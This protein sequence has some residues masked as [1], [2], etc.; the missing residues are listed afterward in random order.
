MTCDVLQFY[1]TPKTLANKAWSLFK[2]KKIRRVLDPSAG[3]G[4]LMATASNESRHYGNH[5]DYFANYRNWDAVEINGEYHANIKAKGGRV[6]GFDFMEM[7]SAVAYSHIIMNPP[8]RHGVK[9]L[10]HAWHIAFDVEIVAILNAQGVRQPKTQDEHQLNRLIQ[11][12]GSV[13]FVQGA[14]EDPDT[15]RTTSVEVALVHITK[16]GD[17]VEGLLDHLKQLTKHT[18]EEQFF[19]PSEGGN[20]VLP[21][22]YIKTQVY[23]YKLALVK[24]VELTQA[25]FNYSGVASRL[26][27]TLAEL[28]HKGLS[29]E[30]AQNVVQRDIDSYRVSYE[31]AH[32]ALLD[33]AWSS[34]IRSTE[35]LDA[36]SSKMQKQVESEF[37]N[38]KSMEF[39]EF[40]IHSFLE[41]LYLNGNS[42]REDMLCD[43]FDEIVKYHSEN[44]CYYLGWKSNDKHRTVGMSIKPKRFILPRFS[45][46][47]NSVDWDSQTQLR[48]MDKVFSMLDGKTKPVFGLL[49]AFT[50]PDVFTR[51]KSNERISTDYFDVRFYPGRGTVHFFPTRPDLIAAFNR[52]VGKIRA[53]LP[54]DET[55]CHPDFMA[56]YDQAGN[57]SATV[58]RK[59]TSVNLDKAHRD[60]VRAYYYA[61]RMDDVE[62]QMYANK[63]DH[64]FGIVEQTVRSRGLDPFAVL[65]QPVSDNQLLLECCA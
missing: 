22:K 5:Y 12:H 56:Q 31:K 39:S 57:I 30:P 63:V 40:N 3:R 53:W 21:E 49:D 34:I 64:F 46:A 24:L 35:V 6:L 37:E 27:H 14:F 32:D 19:D 2:S 48:D 61:D 8:F 47:F 10:L 26:G 52:W 38:I 65:D 16:K 41:G 18:K 54:N 7:E 58:A 50:T 62:K 60:I 55:A 25:E 17:G 1:P 23:N 13:E 20:L 33:S 29:G 45:G 4:D 36:L 9:H 51:L 11:E 44:T 42:L 43:V 28:Q 59:M 15:L